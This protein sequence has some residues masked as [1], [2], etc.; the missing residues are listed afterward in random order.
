MN[1]GAWAKWL[2]IG[3][4]IYFTIGALRG[5]K[6]LE[7]KVIRLDTELDVCH[8]LAEVL[9]KELETYRRGQQP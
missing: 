3:A 9:V 2:I 1:W 6:M 7:E 8:K 5:A 4:C